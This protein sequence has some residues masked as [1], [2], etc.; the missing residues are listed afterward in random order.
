MLHCVLEICYVLIGI[1]KFVVENQVNFAKGCG[2]NHGCGCNYGFIYN[3]GWSYISNYLLKPIKRKNIDLKPDEKNRLKEIS[4]LLNKIV[5][6]LNSR[7]GKK[8]KLFNGS[9][10]K[11]LGRF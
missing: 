7:I 11:T 6:E 3:H 5:N 1:N 8:I 4:A 10:S 9:S 2:C